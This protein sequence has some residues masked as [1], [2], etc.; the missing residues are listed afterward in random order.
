MADQTPKVMSELVRLM[1]NRDDL[2]GLTDDEVIK[3]IRDARQAKKVA[4]T[5]GSEELRRRGW[6]V[7]QI[8][9]A[10]GVHKAQPTRWV[11]AHPSRGDSDE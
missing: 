6:T 11:Q 5:W 3:A 4:E 8:G 2:S 7:E 10:L 9:K 1:T